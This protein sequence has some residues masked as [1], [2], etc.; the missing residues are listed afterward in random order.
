M[1]V[2]S[3]FLSCFKRKQPGNATHTTAQCMRFEL[4]RSDE[5]FS[6]IHG[7]QR[8]TSFQPATSPERLRKSQDSKAQQTAH[9]AQRQ[10]AQLRSVF[11]VRKRANRPENVNPTVVVGKF[12]HALKPNDVVLIK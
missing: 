7:R 8:S 6:A 4:A 11:E 12:S 2:C 3:L 5:P 10:A 1:L 9:R